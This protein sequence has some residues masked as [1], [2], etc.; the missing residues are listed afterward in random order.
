MQAYAKTGDVH[1][2]AK[3]ARI[4]LAT[5]YRM[6]ETSYRSSFKAAQEQVVD[7]LE[8]EAFRRALNGSDGLLAFLLRAWLPDLYREHIIQEHSGTIM[9][10]EREAFSARETLSRLIPIKRERVQ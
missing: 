1:A 8:A 6:L 9:L 3:A 10:S 2:A 7:Q 5:H 4:S